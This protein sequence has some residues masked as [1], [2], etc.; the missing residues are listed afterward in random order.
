MTIEQRYF[1]NTG[2]RVGVL[3][4][5]TAGI[6]FSG[7]EDSALDSILGAACEADINVLD[8]A[9]TYG[10]AEEKLGRLLASR[11]ERFLI[12]TKCGGNLAKLTVLQRSLRK[13]RHS[14]GTMLG[15][16]PPEWHPSILQRNI[17]DSLRRLRTDRI[18]LIQLHSCS[19]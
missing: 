19:E 9:A 6:G 12:F 5:G 4:L 18:D 2:L 16:L 11:R 15:H 8:S 17:E 3:G 7:I 10:D 1:G 14:V 13:L